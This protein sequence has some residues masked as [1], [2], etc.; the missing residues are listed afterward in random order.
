MRP[1]GYL[2]RQTA[3][4]E[5]DR[6]AVMETV[7]QYMVDI[8]TITLNSPEVMGR[9]TFGEK[10]IRAVIEG[11][12]ALYGVYEKALSN[13]P[14]A[15]LYREHLDDRLKQ[16]FRSG[17]FDPFRKRYE[18]IEEIDYNKKETLKYRKG[19]RR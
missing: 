2:L 5:A 17:N 8:F 3:V 18:W 19:K 16:V 11:M 13:E 6:K 15:D 12:A 9:D 10:R 4:L 1:S 14:D 7:R